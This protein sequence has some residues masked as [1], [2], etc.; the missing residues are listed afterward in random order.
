[1]L[2]QLLQVLQGLANPR[3]AHAQP[4]RAAAIAYALGLAHPNDVVLLAGK[5]HEEYQE[6]KGTKF[7]FSDRDHAQAILTIR[8]EAEVAA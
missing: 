6:I 7:A 3:A 8:G 5:G 2:R 1:M 4:E